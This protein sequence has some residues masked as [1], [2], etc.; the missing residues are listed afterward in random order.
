MSTVKVRPTLEHSLW[1]MMFWAGGAI[2]VIGTVMIA[3]LGHWA[4]AVGPGAGAI[5][6]L[7]SAVMA[8]RLSRAGVYGTSFVKATSTGR[9]LTGAWVFVFLFLAGGSLLGAA[10]AGRVFY[11]TGW[12]SAVFGPELLTLVGFGAVLAVLGPGY[13]EYRSASPSKPTPGA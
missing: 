9:A 10:A 8:T 5:A 6:A 4:N 7:A 3:V 13:S 1:L 12:L 11:W 2:G